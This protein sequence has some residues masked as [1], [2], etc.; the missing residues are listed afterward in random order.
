MV[1]LP[2]RPFSRGM[3]GAALRCEHALVYFSYLVALLALVEFRS[4]L[5][6]CMASLARN[7]FVHA[8][9]REVGKIVIK[10]GGGPA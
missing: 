9:D 10:A 7:Q 5:P 8:R 2:C 4:E 3:A 1:E 6:G